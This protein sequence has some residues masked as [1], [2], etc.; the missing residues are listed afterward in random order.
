VQ[1]PEVRAKQSM[2]NII[3]SRNKRGWSEGGIKNFDARQQR[4]N[5]W[6]KREHFGRQR[7]IER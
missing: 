4:S 2:D 6:Q 3:E 1:K 7:L 5:F